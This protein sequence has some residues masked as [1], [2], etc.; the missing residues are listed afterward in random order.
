MADYLIRIEG[1]HHIGSSANLQRG[2][3]FGSR[4]LNP[5]GNLGVF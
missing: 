5:C 2:P 3:F 1:A 4:K